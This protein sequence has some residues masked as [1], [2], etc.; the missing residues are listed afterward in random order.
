MNTIRRY[1][2]QRR[3]GLSFEDMLGQ[4]KG[5]HPN[6]WW[7]LPI[8]NALPYLNN[9]LQPVVIAPHA[10]MGSR[11]VDVVAN[12]SKVCTSERNIVERSFAHVHHMKLSGIN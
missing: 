9:M 6:L 5:Q 1:G 12:S 4:L 10:N 8:N 11:L 3:P 2:F 7:F